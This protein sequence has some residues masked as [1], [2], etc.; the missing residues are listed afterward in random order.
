MDELG[1][2]FA[3]QMFD[4]QMLQQQQPQMPV[5]PQQPAPPLPAPAAGAYGAPQQPPPLLP[6]PP[7]QQMHPRWEQMPMP[8]EIEDR[9]P[10]D[11]LDLLRQRDP[12]RKISEYSSHE[13]SPG[14]E[15][16]QMDLLMRP[17]QWGGQQ[18]VGPLPKGWDMR[19]DVDRYAA[20][21]AKA[22]P[23]P[24][25]QEFNVLPPWNTFKNALNEQ[26][27]ADAFDEEKG[28]LRDRGHFG[29]GL[30]LGRRR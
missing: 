26:Y 7:P 28:G 8:S 6:A 18:V 14:E 1:T 17:Q 15:A 9:R 10:T 23:V 2:W 3:S 30:N 5:M 16:Y 22:P 25:R 12:W 29:Y 21:A 13:M 11:P 27:M 19:G 20:T 24:P 4:P